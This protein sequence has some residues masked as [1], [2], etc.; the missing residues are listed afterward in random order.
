MKHLKTYFRIALATLMLFL[1]YRSGFL[2]LE[3][4]QSALKN[5]T[6]MI[7]GVIIISFQFVMFAF[8]W[9]LVTSLIE[10]ISFSLSLKLHLIGQ[11]FNTFVPGGVGGDVIKAIELSSAINQP[12][13]NT[14]A[15]TLLDR[16]LGLY[17]LILFSFIF[18]SLY[19]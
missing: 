17:S 15:L 11:F 10:K 13:K 19:A 5:P 12:K 4:I 16:L 18:S 8:R 3:K 7:A 14:L 1:L 2:Q 9:R 6:I